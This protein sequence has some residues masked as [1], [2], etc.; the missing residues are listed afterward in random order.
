MDPSKPW[1]APTTFKPSESTG[2]LLTT[3]GKE[4][5][6]ISCMVVCLFHI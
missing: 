3:L 2:K 5:Y 6:S 4:V 1:M